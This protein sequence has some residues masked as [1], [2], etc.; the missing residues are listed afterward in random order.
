LTVPFA[1]SAQVLQEYIANALSKKA[2]GLDEHNIDAMLE[3]LGWVEVLPITRELIIKAVPIRRR[4]G[5]SHWDATITAA[6]L[7]LGCKT[8]YTEDLNSGQDYGGVRASN[9]FQAE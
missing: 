5:L 7:E 1:T 4:F 9:P 6:A 3:L 8:L 2:L